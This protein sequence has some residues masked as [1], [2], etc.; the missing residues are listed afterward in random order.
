MFRR[1]PEERDPLRIISASSAIARPEKLAGRMHIAARESAAP[2]RC[3]SARRITPD[4]GSR[5][6]DRP[7]F[8]EIAMS[9]LEVIAEDR[10][11]LRP[12]SLFGVDLVGPAHKL[13]MQRRTRTLEQAVVD[14]VSHQVMIEAIAPVG[15][16]RASSGRI[17]CLRDNEASCSSMRHRARAAAPADSTAGCGNSIPI[18]EAGS[19]VARS[20]RCRLS[21][22]ASS[23]AWIVGGTAMSACA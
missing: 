12:R 23:S 4:R 11:E 8:T 5:L 3:E 6:V 10:F 19:A 18:T 2:G 16:G 13:D 21:S 17:K 1:A 9:L 22:R 15:V 20:P 14:G 7:E